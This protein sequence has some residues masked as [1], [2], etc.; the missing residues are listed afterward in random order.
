[1]VSEDEIVPANAPGRLDGSF[2]SSCAGA[3]A[4]DAIMRPILIEVSP[5]EL[6][7]KLTILRIKVAKIKDPERLTNVV[8]ELEILER[9]RAECIPETAPLLKLKENLAQINHK[10]WDVE[11]SLRECEARQDFS[12]EF[13][14][15]ARSVYRLNSVR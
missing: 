9:A 1:M 13:V 12:N 3:V 14:E 4:K 2:R 5:G 11:D 10:L 7:D 8:K 6:L 15:L